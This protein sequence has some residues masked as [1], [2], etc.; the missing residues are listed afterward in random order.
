MMMK[1]GVTVYETLQ[2]YVHQDFSENFSFFKEKMNFTNESRIIDLGC[3]TA[4]LAHQ[5]RK[6]GLKYIGVDM[7]LERIQHA[8]K[9]YPEYSFYCKDLKDISTDEIPSYDFVIMHGVVHHM[10]DSECEGLFQFLKNQGCK[11]IGFMDPIMPDKALQNP[12]GTLLA[13]MDQGQ[14]VR[15]AKD[16]QNLLQKFGSLDFQIIPNPRWPVPVGFAVLT[17]N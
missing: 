16:Y 15:N 10:S 5:F 9:K 4:L 1:L 14:F 8:M 13:K 2:N 12:F 3:G 7:D 11:K 17:L 6:H